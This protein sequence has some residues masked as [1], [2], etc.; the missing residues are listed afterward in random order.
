LAESVQWNRSIRS[1][2]FPSCTLCNTHSA[3]GSR[4]LKI[5]YFLFLPI[6]K[7]ATLTIFPSKPPDYI[8]YNPSYKPSYQSFYKPSSKHITP[9]P[10]SVKKNVQ[11][12]FPY[13]S[14]E[15]LQTSGV[16]SDSNLQQK[17]AGDFEA[18]AHNV[19]ASRDNLAGTQGMCSD[20]ICHSVCLCLMWYSSPK[21]RGARLC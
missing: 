12:N 13:V 7:I 6:F 15:K 17:A 9:Q 8:T 21:C 3:S 16:T 11:F 10:S 2:H 5:F 20:C 18:T 14:I 19:Q 4:I 1:L